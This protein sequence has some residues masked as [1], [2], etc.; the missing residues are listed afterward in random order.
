MKLKKYLNYYKATFSGE[1]QE[2]IKRKFLIKIGL[3]EKDEIVNIPMDL[4]IN[5]IFKDI[6]SIKKEKNFFKNISKEFYIFNKKIDFEK[7]VLDNNK[8]CKKWYLEKISKYRDIKVTWEINRLQFLNFL[9]IN[10][11]EEKA[12]RLLDE[13]IVKN[14][15]NIGINW[16]SNLEV[17]I[18]SISI[19]NFIFKLN[20][21]KILEK[22][23]MLLFLHGNHIYNDISYTEKCIPNNHVIGE[24][25]AL[26]CLSN[27]LNFEG[28]EKWISK[29]KQILEKYSYHFHEDGTYEE[30]SLS[31]QRFT[32]QMYMMVFIFSSI[33]KDE[34]LKDKIIEIIKQSLIFFSSI[35]KP[36]GKY[37]DFGDND[38]GLYFLVLNKR[39][40]SD[41]VKSLRSIFDSRINYYGEIQELENIYNI[42]FSLNKIK[43]CINKEFFEV[44]KYYCYKKNLNYIFSHNQKQLFH[45]H[46]DGM[47]LELVLE[48]KNILIDS[49]TFNYNL[50][51]NK[52]RYYRGTKSHNTVWLGEDQSL[53]IGSFR[54]IS[55]LKQSMK[56]IKEQ[57]KRIIEGEIILKNKKHRRKIQFNENLT[58]IIIEDDILNVDG[59]ELNWIF[60]NEILI[61]KIGRNIF[62]INP[63]DYK[64]EILSENNIDI[65][66]CESFYS[67]NYNE[68]SKGKKIKVFPKGKQ[69][70]IKII[71][72]I[73][74]EDI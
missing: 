35:E 10:E 52:R 63:I 41:F 15:Y 29:S 9:V 4:K 71:T 47:A 30:A 49:G 33:V 38:E 43:K 36:N 11:Q 64:V 17:A 34:F 1:I 8:N 12:I 68:E 19:I 37:P 48:N 3:F 7:E 40:F 57:E 5:S 22:Y 18:R 27:L 70:N 74:K 73:R 13:W 44:G 60:S 45:S 58:E 26:Y 46:S 42:K 28:R 24:A 23:K 21:K 51:I 65:E 66:V 14:P 62:G 39:S 6:I 25:A 53:Q 31:Y 56:F 72:K 55:N 2:K 50:D 67:L 16:N 61:E 69:K 20:N 32:L 59:L 54:W